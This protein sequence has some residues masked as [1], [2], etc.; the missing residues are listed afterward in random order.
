MANSRNPATL[1][2]AE[3]K[4]MFFFLIIFIAFLIGWASVATAVAWQINRYLPAYD[5]SMWVL[6][7][8]YIGGAILMIASFILFFLVPW[9][10][11]L[12]TLR[13]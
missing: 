12:A 11:V 4:T 10:N 5:K 7:F 2:V 1:R 9:N 13:S 6:R 3:L 8:F